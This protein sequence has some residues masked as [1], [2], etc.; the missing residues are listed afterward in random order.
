MNEEEVF[1]NEENNEEESFDKR[2]IVIANICMFLILVSI[3]ALSACIY[4]R[5]S[6]YQQDKLLKNMQEA[7]EQHEYASAELTS[8][9]TIELEEYYSTATYTTNKL[10]SY[11]SYTS[12]YDEVVDQLCWEYNDDEEM[13]E[14]YFYGAEEDRWVR[15]SVDS[16][17]IFLSVWNFDTMFAGELQ[18]ESKTFEDVECYIIQ[19][20][21]VTEDESVHYQ[22]LYIGKEDYL[23]KGIVI[24]QEF[25]FDSELDY[26]LA[27]RVKLSY[28]DE[29]LDSYTIPEEFEIFD[30]II[31]TGSVES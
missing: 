10:N 19:V 8:K 18:K 6:D 1:L 25:Y 12:R 7:L 21:P 30:P 16:E 9:T 11:R 17:P 28:S 20:I 2:K 4:I 24:Y 31:L 29:S 3:G 27:S 23:P 15:H 13:Y 14:V 22:E 26:T 5:H